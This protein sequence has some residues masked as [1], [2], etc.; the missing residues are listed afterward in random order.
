MRALEKRGG[1]CPLLCSGDMSDT[2]L[3]L[4]WTYFWRWIVG[5]VLMLEMMSG[6]RVFRDVEVGWILMLPSDSNRQRNNKPYR[7]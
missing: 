7:V 1:F 4:V 6:L 3:G 5:V 2:F